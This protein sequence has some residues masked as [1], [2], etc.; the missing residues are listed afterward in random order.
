MG[1]DDRDGSS[2]TPAPR[3][4]IAVIAVHGVADQVA[5]A[6]ART[7]AELLVSSVPGDVRYR[8]DGDDEVA[9][10]VPPLEPTP[11]AKAGERAKADTAEPATPRGARPIAKAV[12][13]SLRSDLHRPDW[14]VDKRVPMSEAP[15]PTDAPNPG[16]ELTD[17]L[18]FKACRNDM[19]TVAYDTTRLRLKRQ[20]PAG[21]EQ[22]VDVYEMYWA[23]LSR[24]AGSVPRIISELF[25]LLF[26]LS[27][28]GRDSVAAAARQF[29]QGGHHARRWRWLS[30]LQAGLD[31]AFSRVLA[32]LT[33]QL[34]ML[35]LIL[36][37]VGIVAGRP[38]FVGGA[39]LAL[40]WA[41][42]AALLLWWLYRADKTLRWW[43]CCLGSLAVLCGALAW[44]PAHWVVGLAWLGILSLFGDWIL[45]ICDERFPMTR[46]I[47]WMMWGTMLFIVLW[48]ALELPGMRIAG[49]EAETGLRIFT[50]GALRAVEWVLVGNILWWGVAGLMLFA[51]MFVGQ[52]CTTTHGFE[53]RASVATGRLGL[54]ASMCLFVV[55]VMAA[56]AALTTALDLSVA[57]MNYMPLFFTEPDAPVVGAAHFLDLRYRNSTE[58]FS[59]IA[60]LLV[61]MGAY[62][63]IGFFPSVLAEL[64]LLHTGS[65]RLGRWLTFTWRWLSVAVAALMV[66]AVLA[67]A[68]VGVSL[69]SRWLGPPMLDTINATFAFVPRWS[70]DILKPLIWTAASTTLALSALGGVLSRY[71][72]W[73]RAPLDA[74][75][76]VDSHFREFPRRGIPRSR[77]FSR[78]AALLRHVAD[79][80]YERVV[81]V[82][83]SQGTVISTELL[84]YLQY[85]AGQ[86]EQQG[87]EAGRLWRDLGPELH[88]LTA[89]S[90]LRQ[91]YA[92][93]FPVLYRWVGD[94]KEDQA[95]QATR[96]GPTADDVGVRRWVNVF[97]TGDYVGR[98]LWSR[99]ARAGDP[100][101][102][103][104]DEVM[105][106]QDV[107]VAQSV[108]PDLH[109]VMGTRTELDVCLG[110]GAHTHY[111]D[112]DQPIV[113][114]LV[115]QLVTTSFRVGGHPAAL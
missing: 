40:S 89:G 32:I 83:H 63:V 3:R 5:G 26:R 53:G 76:D 9:L 30:A 106:P 79:Q 98:W 48:S 68:V 29:E 77:I 66:L 4:G 102:T 61:L 112:N 19:P 107:Y 101:D 15:P 114:S 113:A 7:L 54:F 24:L 41:L 97:A 84:R 64:K 103:M 99:P 75:L 58:T 42:P 22:D 21:P 46:F 109:E 115:D 72:P 108:A 78:F 43:A 47:G 2:T 39:K 92:S 18:L 69:N 50:F 37:P 100:S 44:T 80:G 70:Q 111:F 25:T 71:V 33:L 6:T 91:L 45:R 96:M 56:W 60:I 95:E 104:V 81:I 51:W 38:H 34:G 105:Q 73:M 74:A 31:W 65:A 86:G 12:A 52:S 82:A 28:L 36:L 85:R 16:V 14:V 1:S 49:M 110:P 94:R 8:I 17:F 93:F 57:G 11:Q 23:D 35:A 67:A 59:I 27:Q 10:R 62:L 20:A 55:L 88:L 87:G 90:P 13:Q